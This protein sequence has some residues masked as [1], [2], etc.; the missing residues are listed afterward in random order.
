MVTFAPAFEDKNRASLC[1]KWLADEDIPKE[2]RLYFQSLANR[3][4]E[5]KDVG[6]TMAYSL[7]WSVILW[8]IADPM[9]RLEMYIK[10][11]AL[12]A[13]LEHEEL[14]RM[15]KREREV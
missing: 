5:N 2:Y 15:R 6:E 9:T 12:R 13:K 11:Q 1:K 4:M 14:E 7:V 10:G 3:V 8:V